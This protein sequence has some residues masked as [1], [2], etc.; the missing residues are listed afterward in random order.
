MFARSFVIRSHNERG[1][2]LIAAMLIM[3]LMAAL[4]IGFTT[5]VMSDQRYRGLENDRTKAFYGAQSG[6]EKLTADLG[7]LFFSIAARPTAA[8]IAALS[9]TPPANPE[10]SYIAPPGVMAYGATLKGSS[11]GQILSGP[12]QGLIASKDFYDL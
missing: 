6:I 1:V 11:N 7:N 8:Q 10:V 9:T 2:A 4:M 12:F 3:M 5:V